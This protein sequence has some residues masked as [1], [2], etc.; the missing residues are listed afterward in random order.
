MKIK[1]T[2]KMPRRQGLYLIK[3]PQDKIEDKY[4]MA[5]LSK[6]D[7]EWF[8]SDYKHNY[9]PDPVEEVVCSWGPRIE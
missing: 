3:Y 1:W 4:E 7:K 9:S 8:V 6:V 5:F 2:K